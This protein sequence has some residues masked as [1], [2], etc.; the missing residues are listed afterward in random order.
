MLAPG[1]GIP[2]VVALLSWQRPRRPRLRAEQVLWTLTE[3]AVLGVTGLDG[4]ASYARRLLAD[5]DAAATKA[6]SALLPQ[7]VEHVLLQADLTAVAPGPLESA[8]ARKL[9]LVAEVE[10]RGGGA[11]YRFTP[12]SVRRALDIGWTATELH[13]F[14]ASVSRTPVPQP[15]EYLVDDTA[16]TFG[17]IRVGHAEA[18]LRADDETALTELLHHPAGGGSRAAAAGADGAGQLDPAGRPAPPAPRPRRRAGR[19]GGRRHRPRRP[20][21]PAPGPDAARA[22]AV[23]RAG[24]R[25]G[26]PVCP[27][28][29]RRRVRASPPSGPATAPRPPGPPVPSRPRRPPARW[30]RCATRPRS[31]RSW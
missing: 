13:E 5:D 26:G 14:L 29:R 16:R 17:T 8:L 11:V 15:L 18:Y 3:A 20:A 24:R 19:R 22:P 30:P 7:P 4:L 10:S 9:Q 6:L 2:S 21:R 23:P 12:S 25:R 28:Y 31:A 1:T 27:A